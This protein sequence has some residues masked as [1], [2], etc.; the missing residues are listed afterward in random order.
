MKYFILLFVFVYSYGQTKYN[1]GIVEYGVEINEEILKKAD[2]RIE[3]EKSNKYATKFVKKLYLN[4]KKIYSS[5]IPY[6]KLHFN[7]N[8]YLLVPIEIMLPE[9]LKSKFIFQSSTYYVDYND[10][11]YLNQFKKRGGTYIAPFKKDYDWKIKNKY[12][13][14]LGF[15]CRKAVLDIPNDNKV[16]AWFT[17]QIPIA[18]SPVRYYGLPGAILEVTTPL[19]HIYAKNIEFKKDVEIEKPTEGIKLSKEEYQE[20]ISRPDKMP[21]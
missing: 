14:I 7:N 17:P 3:K 9:N 10:E 21:D 15:K 5:D 11:N 20:M 4:H 8:K 18:F 6:L 2:D 1:S 13:N 16:I 12:K 19:K